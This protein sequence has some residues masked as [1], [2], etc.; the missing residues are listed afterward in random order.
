MMD[1][2][3]VAA[4]DDGTI[5]ALVIDLP[6]AEFL[7]SEGGSGIQNAA[8]VAVLPREDEPFEQLGMVLQKGNP[9]VAC[10]NEALASLREAGTLAE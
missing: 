1:G 7:L 6:S 10:V 8:V 9:L 3:S 4:I 5:D 2:P